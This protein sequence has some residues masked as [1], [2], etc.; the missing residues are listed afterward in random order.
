ML[1]NFKKIGFSK[2]YLKAGGWGCSCENANEIILSMQM[3][4]EAG[5][6][7]DAL[8]IYQVKRSMRGFPIFIPTSL[9]EIAKREEEEKQKQQ[10]GDYPVYTSDVD[11]TIDDDVES[12]AEPIEPE[13]PVTVKKQKMS[14][15]KKEAQKIKEKYI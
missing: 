6:P 7:D 1:F 3:F 12:E 14:P 9:A 8:R 10:K 5:C 13:E 2:W 15:L 4:V 11:D